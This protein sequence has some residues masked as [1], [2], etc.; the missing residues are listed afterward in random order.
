MK[1]NKLALPCCKKKSDSRYYQEQ[2]QNIAACQII[3]ERLMEMKKKKIEDTFHF[4]NN[5]N[6]FY[7]AVRK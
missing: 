1:K 7:F 3:L 4:S 6:Q 5:F 2:Y